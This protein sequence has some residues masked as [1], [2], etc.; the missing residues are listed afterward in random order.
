MGKNRY[1]KSN[2]GKYMPNAPKVGGI[3]GPEHIISNN[4]NNP[5]EQ[6]RVSD[7]MPNFLATNLLLEM[8]NIFAD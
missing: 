5:R 8:L 1:S 2:P 4:F 3:V 7:K 6:N